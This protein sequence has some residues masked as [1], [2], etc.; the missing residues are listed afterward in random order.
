MTEEKVQAELSKAQAQIP[1]QWARRSSRSTEK[2][3]IVVSALQ[4]FL[5]PSDGSTDL[6]FQKCPIVKDKVSWACLLCNIY[7]FEWWLKIKYH[8]I[9]KVLL[10][11]YFISRFVIKGTNY[12]KTNAAMEMRHINRDSFWAH[13]EVCKNTLLFL[14]KNRNNRWDA[15]VNVETYGLNDW[16]LMHWSGKK[17][18]GKKKKG[19][20][21]QRRD[22]ALKEKEFWRSEEKKRKETAKWMRNYKWSRSKGW[23]QILLR[24]HK[25]SSCFPLFTVIC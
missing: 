20:K 24:K 9:T 13:A 6:T 3:D 21:Q 15:G 8:T 14:N 22:V 18:R 12:R 2:E 16:L 23:N 7:C 19:E 5:C 11:L 17:R 4:Y 10:N 1:S 25:L